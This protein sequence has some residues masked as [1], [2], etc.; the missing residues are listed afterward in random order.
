MLKR[1]FDILVSLCGLCCLSPFLLLIGLLV[2]IRDGCPIFFKQKR[3]GR[4]GSTF[5]LWKF[6]TMV[7]SKIQ[8]TQLATTNDERI[9][10]TGRI[11]RKY[12]IDEFPQLW[13]VLKG[14]MSLVGYRP[15]IPYYVAKYTPEQKKLLQYKPGIVD[16]ATLYFKDENNLL[17]TSQ[18]VEHDYIHKILPIKL[19]LS[20]DYAQRATFR[21][22]LKCI[23]E[24]IFKLLLSTLNKC[25]P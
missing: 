20:L 5:F 16:P 21:S 10:L 4:Y 3:I 8:D 13:N 15:E 24:T 9:T 25:L 14:D 19:K 2:G 23:L 7:D 1:V 17:N 12:K 11:L 6:R 22:D 18:N